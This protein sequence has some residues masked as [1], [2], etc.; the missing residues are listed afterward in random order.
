LTTS[1]YNRSSLPDSMV[2]KNKDQLELQ[3]DNVGDFGIDVA[4]TTFNYDLTDFGEWYTDDVAEMSLREKYPALQDAWNHYEAVKKM[5]MI[6]EK[7]SD[8]N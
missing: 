7:E 1:N 8:E 2:K 3:Y 6:R 5:C 4:S